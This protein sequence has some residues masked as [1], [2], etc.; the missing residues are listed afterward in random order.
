[1]RSWLDSAS[2]P[3]GST[4]SVTVSQLPLQRNALAGEPG[5]LS[6]QPQMPIRGV[7][8]SWDF[9]E[10]PVFPPDRQPVLQAF[11]VQPKLAIGAVD[12]PLEHEADRV[13]DQVML[14]PHPELSIAAA[15]RQLSRKCAA[16]EEEKKAQK[17]QTKPAGTAKAASEAPP[18][19][20]E[21]LRSPGQRL[22]SAT[23]AYFEP[24][25]G[26]DFGE[27]RVHTGSKPAESARAVN[28]LAYTLGPDVVFGAEQYAPMT[29]VGKSLLAHELAHV[30]QQRK[31]TEHAAGRTTSAT[32][33]NGGKTT[34][35]FDPAPTLRRFVGEE[36]RFL[37]EAGSGG[38]MTEIVAGNGAAAVVLSYGDVV[39]MAGDFFE[40]I[41][42]ML[43]LSKTPSGRDELLWARWKALTPRA[44]A[45]EPKVSDTVKKSVN[46]RYYTLAARNISHF[47]AGGTAASAYDQAHSGA[48]SKGYESGYDNAVGW[49]EA[50][51]KWGEAVEREAFSN[52]YLTDMFSAGHVRTERAAIKA[53]YTSQFP[54]SVDQFV[55]YIATR[56]RNFLLGKHPVAGRLPW[57]GVPGQ[58]EL[59]NRIRSIGGPAVSAFSLGD[60]VSLAFHNRDNEGLNVIADVDDTGQAVK[61]YWEATGDANL[62]KSTQ[63]AKMAIA[64]VK[65]SVA[66]LKFMR[67]EGEQA[68]HVGVYSTNYIASLKK[69]L[70]YK[71]LSFV[72]KEDIKK[73]NVAMDWHWGSFNAEMR[74][75]VDKAI[76]EDVADALKDKADEQTDNNIKD[77]LNDFVQHLK[78][79]G[80]GAIEKA[81]GKPAGP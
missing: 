22:D 52:H 53:W 13:A 27:V 4:P 5:Q 10:T 77:A 28:A 75:A 34:L 73:G 50:D 64:A 36:H 49:Y 16:Y 41:E 81:I 29:I 61:T 47:S 74:A 79:V 43:D 6:D 58:S 9:S 44:K 78:S 7:G 33:A 12:D 62:W 72:P 56:I 45:T 20:Y 23:R 3:I 39:A 68:P 31:Y 48:L 63:T 14:V 60:V 17:L 46:D 18:I 40:N 2:A 32:Q 42:Q 66:D 37:G 38:M 54:T 24:R 19:V 21:V 25:F 51:R 8:R 59:E 55:S 71:A 80:I 26:S 76:K 1:V 70:P 65:A 67:A 30:I 11:G 35:S 15:P 57:V 69:V